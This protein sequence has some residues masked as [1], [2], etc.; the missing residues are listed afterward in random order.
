IGWSEGEDGDSTAASPVRGHRR[1]GRVVRDRTVLNQHGAV[2]IQQLEAAAG[3]S[4]RG[5]PGNRAVANREAAR[6]DE[7]V[8]V[9]AAAAIQAGPIRI[10]GNG[11][12]LHQQAAAVEEVD[13]AA[14]PGAAISRDRT[15]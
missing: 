3:T 13:A 12:V 5:V 7:A 10:P 15:I 4:G 11:A 2:R 9:D 14:A 1:A 6:A 8:E